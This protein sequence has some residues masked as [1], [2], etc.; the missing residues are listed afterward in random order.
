MDVLTTVTGFL[1]TTMGTVVSTVTANPL[2]AVGIGVPVV[3]GAIG[4]F[5]SLV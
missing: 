5:K 2:L 4:L 1:F 3:G